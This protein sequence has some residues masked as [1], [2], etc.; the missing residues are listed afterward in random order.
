MLEPPPIA[1]ELSK[2]A[3]APVPIATALVTGLLLTTWPLSFI[4]VILSDA[5]PI[6][7][8]ALPARA[9]VP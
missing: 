4:R 5:V 7:T 8:P 9:L 2:L 1:T 3:R 6:A